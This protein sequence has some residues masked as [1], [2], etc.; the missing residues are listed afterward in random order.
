MNNSFFE[1]CH[2]TA[3]WTRALQAHRIRS[4]LTCVVGVGGKGV[5]CL[6]AF[7]WLW[8]SKSKPTKE[9][10]VCRPGKRV[11]HRCQLS[12]TESAQVC[13]PADWARWLHPP[14]TC[15]IERREEGKQS[16]DCLCLVFCFCFAPSGSVRGPAEDLRGL[17]RDPGQRHA[18]PAFEH[19]D[20]QVLAVLQAQQ[21]KDKVT[22]HAFLLLGPSP[23]GGVIIYLTG[24]YRT[25]SAQF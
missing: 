10:N 7:V 21:S 17:C 9:S 22:E 16:I 5:R 25:L 6:P 12:V 8:V 11:S 20:P 4:T 2:K 23:T 14:V 1:H 15:S 18:G 3:R 13:C 19:H 24:P